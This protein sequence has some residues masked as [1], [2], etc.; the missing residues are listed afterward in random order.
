MVTKT[1]K[2]NKMTLKI[3]IAD[4][5]TDE[6][7]EREMNEKELAQYEA[8]TVKREARE[9]VKAI[10]EADKVAAKA[11]AQAKLA[12]LGLTPDEVTAIIGA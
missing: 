3:T 12:A 5:L 11:S 4:A 10:A 6:V 7:I 9:K 2:D 8:D 1:V